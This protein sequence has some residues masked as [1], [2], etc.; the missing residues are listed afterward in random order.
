[1]KLP[2]MEKAR[3]NK[4]LGEQK[5]D[6][7]S[8]YDVSNMKHLLRE[9]SES[10][11]HNLFFFRTLF[12]KRSQSSSKLRTYFFT[13]WT[14][15][16]HQKNLL[17]SFFRRTVLR[18]TLKW[19]TNCI[20]PCKVLSLVLFIFDG[21]FLSVFIWLLEKFV[22]LAAVNNLFPNFEKYTCN[23]KKELTILKFY[24]IEIN[25]LFPSIKKCTYNVSYWHVIFM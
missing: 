6:E 5:I 9:R 7:L 17:A 1:M 2:Q 10:T 25:N 8:D 19:Y 23:E 3:Q 11:S 21:F 15:G 13:C 16:L 24:G 4:L 14:L 12:L 22:A 18:G 20:I